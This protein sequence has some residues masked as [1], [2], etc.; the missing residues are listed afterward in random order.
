[1]L[2]LRDLLQHDPPERL[3]ALQRDLGVKRPPAWS[4]PQSLATRIAHAL[5]DPQ[6]V[7]RLVNELDPIEGQVFRSLFIHGG[8]VKAAE[9]LR[10]FPDAAKA[11]ARLRQWLLL[12]EHPL[13]KHKLGIDMLCVPREYARFVTLT[14]EE[15]CTLGY[16][17]DQQPSAY[18]TRLATALS[19]TRETGSKGYLSCQAREKLLDRGFLKRLLSRLPEP[20]Q[21][22]FAFGLRADGILQ[23]DELA[24]L[25]YKH[26]SVS[27]YGG[28]GRSRLP[29][30]AQELYL[31]GLIFP[32]DPELP[33]L[34]VI[35]SDL[36]AL[37]RD[38]PRAVPAASPEAP[39][40]VRSW[41]MRLVSD[42]YLFAGYLASG[43]LRIIRKGLPEKKGVGTFLRAV[44][45]EEEQYGFFLYTL[46]LAGSAVEPFAEVSSADLIRTLGR[47]VANPTH[48]LR[49]LIQWW[50]DSD[51]WQE[52]FAWRNRRAGPAAWCVDGS[53][54]AKRRLVLKALERVPAQQWIRLQD[55]TTYLHDLGWKRT[56][57]Y[58]H[59]DSE[60]EAPWIK[61]EHQRLG[62]AQI[63]EAI[64]G[65]SLTWLGVVEAGWAP[66]SS[67]NAAQLSHVRVT[68]WGRFVLGN[69]SGTSPALTP[70]A[71]EDRFS[72]LPNLE[73]AVP[74]RLACPLLIE[75]FRMAELSGPSTFRL[76][77]ESLRQAL[78]DG[79]SA[80]DILRFLETHS[81]TGMPETVRQFVEE[82]SG[83]HGQIKVGLAGSYL[84]VDDPLLLVELKSHK[85]LR[86]LIRKEAGNQVALLA[87]PNPATVAKLLKK[88]GYLP[89]VEDG[90]DEAVD[91]ASDI[92]RDRWSQADLK[93]RRHGRW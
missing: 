32:D 6:R 51:E 87:E 49:Q 57:L 41:G 14:P 90:D 15:Q 1:M 60:Y 11:V 58:A 27:P 46:A 77:K 63:L 26:V 3:Q 91:R 55:V 16:L 28:Y 67:K 5:S 84:E 68:E 17:L 79:A 47:L 75:M 73:I 56:A 48:T 7:N 89:V 21:R 72:V 64:L 83:K 82:L 69:S 39:A 40:S 20:A 45:V 8:Q 31:H 30:P 42:L 24:G 2:G 71:E 33:T 65:E 44:G 81:T 88:L 10:L 36:V 53:L 86:G 70:I 66:G 18:H 9:L 78:D 38:A 54:K 93:K 80:K 76:T 61:K 13:L 50:A 62:D 22:L 12:F 74:P 59:R 29:D 85:A 19:L 25:G 37:L 23:V 52:S 4:A 34:L 35:P 92:V 43:R